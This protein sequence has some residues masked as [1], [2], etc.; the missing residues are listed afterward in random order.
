MSLR[1]AFDDI[2]SVFR[3]LDA[4]DPPLVRLREDYLD[5]HLEVE[6]DLERDQAESLGAT[7]MQITSGRVGLS[8]E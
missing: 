4:Q 3:V 1:V 7:L 8:D 5:T 6:L 2:G